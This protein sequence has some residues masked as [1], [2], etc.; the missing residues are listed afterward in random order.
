[1]KSQTCSIFKNNGKTFFICAPNFFL[2][3]IKS[4]MRWSWWKNT[5]GR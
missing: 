1:M 3:G 4:A 5:A 2:K